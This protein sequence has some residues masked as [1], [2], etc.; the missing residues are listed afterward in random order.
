MSLEKIKSLLKKNNFDFYYFE[1]VESTMLEIKKYN[2]KKN[3]CLMANQQTKGF[4]RRGS[5]WK[6]PEGNVYISILFKNIID[7]QHH[8][9]NNAYITNIICNVIDKICNV[10]TEIKWPNDILIDNKKISGIIS[11]IHSTKEYTLTN[12]GFGVNIIS[13]PNVEEYIT[14]N[15]NEYKKD[16]NNFEF[17]FLLMK[18]YFK[19]LYMLNDQSNIILENYKS[20]LKYLGSQI[21]LKIDDNIFKEGIFYNLNSDGSILLKS[22]LVSE[23]IYNARILK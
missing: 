5:T 18:E 13:S 14:T 22:N 16:I 3:I 11:E 10:K 20:R 2:F 7:I 21:R 15:I 9:L 12:T 19:Y 17:T 8:F 4:G 1:T 23:N 6:S